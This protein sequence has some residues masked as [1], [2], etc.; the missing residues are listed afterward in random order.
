PSE[1]GFQRGRAEV[2]AIAV[3]LASI[4]MGL[5]Y[6][7]VQVPAAISRELQA[8]GAA[9]HL[10]YGAPA[11]TVFLLRQVAGGIELYTRQPRFIRWIVPPAASLLVIGVVA[12]ALFG[13]AVQ[14]AA[15]S[16]RAVVLLGT[17]LAA[18]ARLRR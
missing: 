7:L 10:Y 16:G 8:G 4:A 6:V 9:I 11:A 15:D 14:L 17:S 3:I 5:E 2:A 13:N 18:R 1:H 12:C